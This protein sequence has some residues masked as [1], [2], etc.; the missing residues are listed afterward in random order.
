MSAIWAKALKEEKAL[1]E[2]YKEGLDIIFN[3]GYGCCAFAHNI[4][5]SQ[6]KVPD[7]M[8]DM[9]K[10]LSAEFFNNPRCPPSVVPTEAASI[11]IRPGEVTNAPKREAPAVVLDM[12][13]SKA[14]EHLSAT[15]VG[16][17]N[18]PVFSI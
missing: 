11:D 10:P 15:K 18:E 12:D 13:N 7:G 16:P 6:P 8:S 1:E 2:A 4:F 5:E 14:S 3:Y 9:S 17:S